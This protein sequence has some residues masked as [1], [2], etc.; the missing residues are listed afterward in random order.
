MESNTFLNPFYLFQDVPRIALIKLPLASDSDLC[1]LHRYPVLAL[2]EA[3]EILQAIVKVYL[4]IGSYSGSESVLHD[5]VS[6]LEICARG[7]AF[8]ATTG[9]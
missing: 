5:P 8:F 4:P 9:N 6:L 3:L 2:P 7:A 1:A